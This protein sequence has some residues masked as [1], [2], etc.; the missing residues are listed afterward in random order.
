MVF[1]VCAAS[2][3]GAPVWGG[4]GGYEGY[5]HGYYGHHGVALSGPHLGPVSVGGPHVGPSHLAGDKLVN[6]FLFNLI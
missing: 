3:N 2:I 4:H 6:Q 1:A 5:G